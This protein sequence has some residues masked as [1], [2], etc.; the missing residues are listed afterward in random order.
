[1]KWQTEFGASEHAIEFG[2]RVHEDEEDRLQRNSTYHQENG[3]LLLDDLGLL[4]NAGNRVQAAEASS[5]FLYD[6]ISLG[7]LTLT[8]G[9]RYES[10]DQQRTRWEIR[11]G[12]TTDPSS[13]A[14]SNIRDGRG[15]S[16][17]SM[18]SGHGCALRIQ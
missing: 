2:V 5:F 12:R 4:G 3:E 17:E 15:K 11:D 9:I 1:M 7:N 18:D 13:R 14:E 10:I 8:P 16:N 6:D